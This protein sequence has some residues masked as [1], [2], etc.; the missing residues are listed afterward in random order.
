VGQHVV[1]SSVGMATPSQ[2]PMAAAGNAQLHT[3]EIGVQERQFEVV[4]AGAAAPGVH[5]GIEVRSQETE[6]PGTGGRGTATGH[7]V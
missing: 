5:T 4:K 3:V 2:V 6:V 1:A 7:R